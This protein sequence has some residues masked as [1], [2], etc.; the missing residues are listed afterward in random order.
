MRDD[1]VRRFE[2]RGNAG[3]T[4]AIVAFVLGGIGTG[5]LWP[6]GFLCVGL[7]VA[8]LGAIA[9]SRGA[10]ARTLAQASLIGGWVFG[11]PAT[12]VVVLFDLKYVDLE[13][14]AFHEYLVHHYPHYQYEVVQQVWFLIAFSS[15]GIICAFTGRIVAGDAGTDEPSTARQFT[16]RQLMAFFI[17]VAIYLGYVTAHW[18]R[19][20]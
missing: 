16:L 4:G 20:K 17:P 3:M 18:P 1:E 8:I 5:E 6:P 19:H 10:S 7:V 13:H 12:L 9:G 15:L 11:F 14:F 2:W